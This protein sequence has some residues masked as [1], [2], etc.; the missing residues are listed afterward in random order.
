MSDNRAYYPS[1]RS[2]STVLS[3]FFHMIWMVSLLSL[4]AWV[5][6]FFWFSVLMIKKESNINNDAQQIVNCELHFVSSFHPTGSKLLLKIMNQTETFALNAKTI[7]LSWLKKLLTRINYYTLLSDHF[8]IWIQL[9]LKTIEIIV[10][11]LCIFFMSIPLLLSVLLIALVDGLG[12]RDIR[13]FQGAREST[14]F[15]HRMKPVSGKI[16]YLLFLLY[17]CLPWYLYPPTLL[18]PM[19]ALLS[20]TGMQTIKNYKKYI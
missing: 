4:L 7:T 9:I 1:K 14:F 3:L 10:L 5:L 8:I 12:Q 11:R 13:K 6:L 2:Y 16:F 19:M 15:F 20:V 18:F 17:L